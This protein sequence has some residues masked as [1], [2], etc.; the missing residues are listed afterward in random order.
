MDDYVATPGDLPSPDGGL[1]V[2]GETN[3][4]RPAGRQPRDEARSPIRVLP[5][6][7]ATRIAAGEVVERPASVVKELIE[8]ALDAGAA[9]IRV[10][11][12]GGGLE[13]IRVADDGDGIP[14]GE[15][16]LAC[17]RHATSKLPAGPRGLA[18]TL[19]RVQTLG[20]R[21]EALPSIAAV[22]ELTIVTATDMSG[23][24]HRVSVLDGRLAADGPA[25]RPRGTTVTARGLF[26]NVPV[27]LAAAARVQTEIAQIVL[28]SRRLALAA[29]D[30]ALEI[31]VED[32]IALRTSGSGDLATTLIEVYGSGIRG[33]LIS[34]PRLTI[35]ATRIWGVVSG[36]ELTRPG[37]DGIHLIVNGR[38][39]QPRGLSHLL[40]TAYRPL[41]PRGRHPLLVIAIETAPSRV[42]VNI[43]PAKLDVRL[44]D[45]RAIGLAIGEQIRSTLGQQPVQLQDSF[46]VGLAALP[47]V[48]R[49]EERTATWDEDAPIVTP[50][51][52]P[53]R[54]VGQVRRRMLLLE[55]SAGLYLI[56]QHRA[57]ERMIYES[58]LPRD[59][60]PMA[61]RLPLP[62][63]LLLE[64][65]PAQERQ[66]GRRL[67]DLAALGF[68]LE[69]FGGRAFLLRAVPVL[70]G[71]SGAE[72]EG[73][74]AGLGLAEE[75]PP[76]LIDGL[77]DDS[78]EGWREHL[79]IRL[80]CRTAVRRGRQLDRDA[81][82]ALVEGVGN[83]SAPAVCP[84][85]S[86]MLMHVGDDLLHRQ[87]DWD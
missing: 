27:R 57:H 78:G 63:P 3:D 7:V 29:P 51:L 28:T 47:R 66:L 42:D 16:W 39:V 17:Q 50:G 12:R 71:L 65:R 81:M 22:S 76:M 37:R 18:S 69:R 58:L 86:P 68:E 25:P 62:D 38:A 40:E 35:A 14:R 41:V 52:P 4:V 6:I 5:E 45:E 11:V 9:R 43:H 83:T 74:Q 77:D 59:G 55:G 36:P 26:Q 44:R 8:N 19:E 31:A 46:A 60:R 21:G 1:P 53:L 72:S 30:V 82:R 85:G 32:R 2:T 33:A 80:A 87:F 84:H 54:L 49:L 61:E 79:L 67:D 34:L 64:L 73:A 10:D 24:G 15:L 70:P 56:D 23:I 48:A 13:T 75:L 20:F